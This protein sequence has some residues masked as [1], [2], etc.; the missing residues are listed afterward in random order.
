MT[1][2]PER[3]FH[4]RYTVHGLKEDLEPFKNFYRILDYDV[5]TN[6]YIIA[7]RD[8]TECITIF[9]KAFKFELKSPAGGKYV[10]GQG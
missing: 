1:D 10:E 6:C 9:K 8:I 4:I 5:H 7:V 2:R 3:V